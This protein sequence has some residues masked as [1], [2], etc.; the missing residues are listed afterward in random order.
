MKREDIDY[1]LNRLL[2]GELDA[3]EAQRLM[4][5]I[6]REPALAQRYRQYRRLRDELE[7]LAADGPA[8]DWASQR[9]SIHAKLERQALLKPSSR[10]AILRLVRWSATT[11]AAAAVIAGVLLTLHWFTGVTRGGAGDRMQVVVVRPSAI[12]GAASVSAVRRGEPADGGQLQVQYRRVG[13]RPEDLAARTRGIVVVSA[14]PEAASG[15]TSVPWSLDE[16]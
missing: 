1:Q 13:R 11:A 10:P 15:T 7:G 5:R 3:G 9:E 6:E 12:V 2:E 16:L 14:G 4:Q 8:V